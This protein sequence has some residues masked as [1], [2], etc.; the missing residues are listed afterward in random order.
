VRRDVEGEW[1]RQEEINLRY[2]TR[3][4][5]PTARPS[6][7]TGPRDRPPHG[8]GVTFMAKYD[9]GA[10]GSSFHLTRRSGTRPVGNPSSPRAPVRGREGSPLFGHWLAASSRWPASCVLLRAGREL[11]QALSV[12]LFAPTRIVAGGTIARAAS[13]SAREGSGLRVENRIPGADANPYLAFAAT[14]AAGLHGVAS[15]LKA[16]QALRGERVRGLDAPQVP[17]TLREAI[18]ELEARGRARRLGERVVEHYL[19]TA[20]SN[21]R[22]STGG[23]GLGADAQ[24]SSGSDGGDDNG[25]ADGY[26]PGSRDHAHA[27]AVP[28]RLGST[29]QR[30]V[31]RRFGDAT[32]QI[33]GGNQRDADSRGARAWRQPGCPCPV[34]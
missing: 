33:G 34:E 14:I 23:H 16:A 5:W 8:L 20:G 28:L 6:T 11:L 30:E 12:G 2:P 3:S 25:G 18:A 26:A 10:A 24:T 4:R 13:G 17:K 21:S 15:R 7:S 32:A 29:W 9:M 19:H 1:G 27:S 22:P 31:R